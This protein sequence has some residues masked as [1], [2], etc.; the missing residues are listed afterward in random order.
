M[1]LISALCVSSIETH[2]LTIP[3]LTTDNHELSRKGMVAYMYARLNSPSPD[4]P[5]PSSCKILLRQKY[6]GLHTVRV[7]IKQNTYVCFMI[8]FI[9]QFLIEQAHTH[10]L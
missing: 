7:I 10:M 9:P 2:I 4:I 8:F 3:N 6:I 5:L 1:S